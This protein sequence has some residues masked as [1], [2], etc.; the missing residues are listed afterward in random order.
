[1]VGSWH[2]TPLW[3][4]LGS[5]FNAFWTTIWL[6]FNSIWDSMG[7]LFCINSILKHMRY[8]VAYLSPRS[9]QLAP[10]APPIH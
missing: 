4:E 3:V 5:I 10:T 8:E 9:N 2:D 6:H 7:F 1:M